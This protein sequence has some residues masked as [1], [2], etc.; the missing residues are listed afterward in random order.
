MARVDS[1]LLFLILSLTWLATSCGSAVKKNE[2][3]DFRLYLAKSNRSAEHRAIFQQLVDW[4]NTKAGVQAL[5]YANV[6]EVSNSAIVVTQGLEARD[7]KVGWGQSITETTTDSGALMPG[8]VVEETVR[9]FMRVEFDADFLER[10]TKDGVAD[11]EMETLFAHEV[12]HG[13]LMEHDKD[14][15]SVMYETVGE[16]RD[17]DGYFKRVRAFF[18]LPAI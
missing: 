12:G 3:K 11:S 8:D 9:Y 13:L 16:N 6:G 1:T 2:V 17:F 7:K 4:Y 15:R 10:H 18:N 5:T 14:A